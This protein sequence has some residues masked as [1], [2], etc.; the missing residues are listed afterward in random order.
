MN[1]INRFFTC[2]S[3]NKK[4]KINNNYE[5]EQFAMCPKCYKIEKKEYDRIFKNI[6]IK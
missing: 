5:N 2:V 1:N 6:P 3:C 4:T